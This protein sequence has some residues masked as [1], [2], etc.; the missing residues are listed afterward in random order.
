MSAAES[1]LTTGVVLHEAVAVLDKLPAADELHWFAAYTCPRHEKCVRRQL[2]ERRIE[3]FLPLY[4]SMRR[5]K[6]RRKEIEFA[7]FPGYVFVR[8]RE[9]ERFRVLDL[10]G[11]VYL[12]SFQGRSA[13]LPDAEIES[14]RSGLANGVAAECHPFLQTGR[15]VRV[16]RGPVAG[17][18]GILVRRKDKVRVVISLEAIMQS[19]ALEVDAADVEAIH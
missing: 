2:E 18:Q 9:R 13:A 8:I 6:D 14:L 11:V 17:M 19:V 4:R 12:V 16:V 15:K 5:W 3:S 10:P 1:V 7:L